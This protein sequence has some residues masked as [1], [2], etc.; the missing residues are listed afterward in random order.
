MDKYIVLIGG[1]PVQCYQG[2]YYVAHNYA[3]HVEGL[4]ILVDYIVFY[5]HVL[6]VQTIPSGRQLNSEKIRVIPSKF[7]SYKKSLS[8]WL[9]DQRILLSFTQNSVG[10]IESFP[11]GTG[12]I[13][14]LY[15][16]KK[17]GSKV[18][19]LK[20]DWRDQVENRL[21]NKDGIGFVQKIRRLYYGIS[22]DLAVMTADGVLVRGAKLLEVYKRKAKYIEISQP[23]ASFNIELSYKRNDCCLNKTINLLYVGHLA[24]HKGIVELIKAVADAQNLFGANRT[25]SITLIGDENQTGDGI[26]KQELQSFANTAGIGSNIV[27][28]GRIDDCSQLA[29][30]YQQADIFLLAS[31][32]EGFPRVINEALL[33]S[34][35]VIATAVGGIPYEL[36]D[37]KELLLVPPGDIGAIAKGI[38]EIVKNEKL[39]RKLIEN[40]HAWA[41][42]AMAEASWKQHARLLGLM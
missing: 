20:T 10:W 39:R 33:L 3:Q 4:S 8:N 19:Y 40:G 42:S 23:L 21:N 1:N 34:L 31:H 35:P 25:L 16:T 7:W 24:R 37:R 2:K 15:Y 41:L 26:P 36:E 22:Q 28:K 12:L 9:S 27:F 38:C 32:F 14:P 18:V 17:R 13:C 29:K 5:A 6:F 11:S 30:H